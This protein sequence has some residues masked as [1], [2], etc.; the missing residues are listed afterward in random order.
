[1]GL[2]YYLFEALGATIYASEV[3][4][5]QNVLNAV[6]STVVELVEAEARPRGPV[7]LRGQWKPWCHAFFKPQQ[8]AH[9]NQVAV[10]HL[11]LPHKVEVTHG[12]SWEGHV[13]GRI[14]IQH[15]DVIILVVVYDPVNY[16]EQESRQGQ[17]EDQTPQ[18]LAN[19]EL[20]ALHKHVVGAMERAT[21]EES[22]Q[23]VHL[24]YLVLLLVVIVCLTTT[25]QVF[26]RVTVT[27][28]HPV[29]VVKAVFII[30]S[31]WLV[32]RKGDGTHDTDRHGG[33]MNN[34]ILL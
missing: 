33:R 31:A 29:M 22:G 8:G 26:L 6:S 25:V 24:P 16:L 5:Q 9:E 13:F 18:T 30:S 28:L 11:R 4:L 1:M 2:Q 3:T 15:G 21:A 34:S 23:V 20:L 14:L 17:G 32:V 27:L 7:W 10:A 19:T 12:D